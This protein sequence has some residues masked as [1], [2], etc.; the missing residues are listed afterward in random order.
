MF[1]LKIRVNGACLILVPKAILVSF[2]FS[3]AVRP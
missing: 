1:L 3:T 2:S